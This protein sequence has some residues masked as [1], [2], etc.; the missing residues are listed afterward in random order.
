MDK[1]QTGCPAPQVYVVPAQPQGW[2][3]LSLLLFILWI[4]SAVMA[5]KRKAQELPVTP[6]GIELPGPQG[7]TTGFQEF[8]SALKSL[9]LK[10]AEIKAI[11]D[12]MD[13]SLPLE[14]QIREAV[15]PK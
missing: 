15:A 1:A 2:W 12:G 13:Q 4:R 3:A 7:P 10:K 11:W 5:R 9:G 6:P 14:Q 8:S